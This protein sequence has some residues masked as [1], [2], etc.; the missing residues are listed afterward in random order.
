MQDALCEEVYHSG[1]AVSAVGKCRDCRVSVMIFKMRMAARNTG[2]SVDN[3][4]TFVIIQG[5]K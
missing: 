5:Y 1:E 3:F 2:K 4:L